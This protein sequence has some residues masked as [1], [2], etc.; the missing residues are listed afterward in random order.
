M[1]VSVPAPALV[2]PP[3]LTIPSSVTAEATVS[4]RV[5]PVKLTVPVKSRAPLL[6]ALPSVRS[7]VR[8]RLFASVRA[9]VPSLEMA[10]AAAEI[11]PVPKA[12]SLPAWRVPVVRT[13]PPE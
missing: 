1:R 4:V 9:V 3:L 8:L 7:P 5:V 13:V 6:V 2:R 11:V 10:P 12:A